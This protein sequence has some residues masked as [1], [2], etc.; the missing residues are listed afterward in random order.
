MIYQI[1]CIV[2][3]AWVQGIC[4]LSCSLLY[5]REFC[6]QMEN[7]PFVCKNANDTA[8]WN[9]LMP[10]KSY[11]KAQLHRYDL[12]YTN[13]KITTPWYYVNSRRNVDSEK[14]ESQMGFEP[15]TRRDLV[16]CST[17]ELLVT[18]WRAR[19]KLWVLTGTASRGYTATCWLIWTH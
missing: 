16:G 4:L 6:C 11:V 17:T 13:K 19:V 5:R 2:I 14:S 1:L 3:W 7:L 18:L 9:W 10:K 12:F 15:T 8:N